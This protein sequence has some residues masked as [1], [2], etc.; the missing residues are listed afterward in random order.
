LKFLQS[1]VVVVAQDI[2]EVVVVAL[3]VLF[4]MPHMP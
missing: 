4:T 3:A 1:L 2:M